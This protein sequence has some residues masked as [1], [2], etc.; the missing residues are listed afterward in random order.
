VDELRPSPDGSLE[1]LER[2]EGGRHQVSRCAGPPAVLGWATGRLPEPKNNPHIGMV[3]MRKAMPAVQKAK[4]VKLSGAG[5]VFAEVSLPKQL[6]ETR[7]V[8]DMS[9]EA[10]ARELA[11]WIKG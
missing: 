11:A 6:R 7:V 9:P 4:P 10:I 2:I 5:L 1:V 8:E 3:N